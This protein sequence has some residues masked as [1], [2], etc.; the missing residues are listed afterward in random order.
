MTSML[1]HE[2]IADL[3]ERLKLQVV[4][5][6]Y[7]E[8]AQQAVNNEDSYVDFLARILKA[9]HEARQAR[10]RQVLVKMAGF[11]TIKTLDDYDYTF[12]AGAPK[13]TIQTLADL[14][15]IERKENIIL[16]GPSGTGKTHLAIALGYLATQHNLKVRFMTATD[17]ILQLETARRQG[18]YQ[19]VLRRSVMGPS[20]LIIDEIGYLPLT[21]D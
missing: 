8:W 18:R 16:L 2:Q 9:E 1:L 17:L 12:A 6:Q 5:D 15:F 14:A 11:P 10:S 19:E 4:A 7:E 21:G 13:K 3:C 20:L